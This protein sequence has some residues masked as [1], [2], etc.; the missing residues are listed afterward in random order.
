ML[1]NDITM[2]IFSCDKFSD[3]WDAHVSQLEK[4]WGDRNIETFIVT[5]RKTEKNYSNVTILAAGEDADFTDRLSYALMEVKTEYVFVTL[6]DYFL[7]QRVSNERINELI[8]AMKALS[9]DYV[10]L[11]PNPRRANVR[12]I[13]GYPFLISIDNS[14]MYSVNLY[15]GIWKKEFIKSTV[16]ERKNPWQ[17]EVSLSAIAQEYKAKCAVSTRK[18]FVILDVVRKGK[19]LNKANWYLKKHDIYHGEREVHSYGYEIKAD[20]KRYCI[21]AMP[22]PVF[23]LV[24]KAMIKLGFHFYSQDV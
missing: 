13:E 24:R 3:L 16:R 1:R 2:L 20:I 9:L 23:N 5:D 21:K 15:A 10:R 22:K 18:E 19:I 17:Y 14:V 7:I 11:F 4:Y 8:A 6:D 12:R